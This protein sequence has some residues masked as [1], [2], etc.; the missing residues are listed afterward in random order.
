MLLH[1]HSFEL[2]IQNWMRRIWKQIHTHYASEHTDES[3]CK[4]ESTLELILKLI[5]IVCFDIETSITKLKQSCAVIF[6]FCIR[7]PKEFVHVVRMR[8]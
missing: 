2:Q 6:Y 8:N 1:S 7:M 3:V 4:A 5:L